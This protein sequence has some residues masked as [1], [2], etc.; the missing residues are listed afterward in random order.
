MS[1][2]LWR[3][4]LEHFA[5]VGDVSGVTILLGD[6]SLLATAEGDVLRA[7]RL[8]AASL[9]LADV[10]GAQLGLARR[11]HRGRPSGH[12]LAR[13]RRRSQA[14]DR[15]GPGDDRRAGGRVR[16]VSPRLPRPLTPATSRREPPDRHAARG[17]SSGPAIVFLD[18]TV[19]NVALQRIGQDLPS[20]FFGVLEGQSY[21][22][23]AYLLSLS[24]L[25][26]LAGAL[27][28]AYGRRRLFVIGLVGFGAA[29]ILCGLAPN[30]ET[31]IALPDRPGRGRGAAR[32]GLAGAAD[33]HVRGR[34]A[35]PRL[36]P[37]G[38]RVR[39]D[40]D[41]RAGR[42]RPPRRDGLVAGRLLPQRAA[43]RASPCGRPGGT[44]QESRD[45][46]AGRSVRLARAPPWWPWPWAASRSARSTAS[47]T[48][49][50]T[51]SGRSRWSSA[52]SR[53]CCSWSS[54]RAADIRSCR[55]ACSG[56]ATSR[57]RT[58][59]RC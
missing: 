33:E 3:E 12:R 31:L 5:A 48:T 4:A 27:A 10:G 59:P 1:A 49:G 21:V 44:S 53:A 55:S 18:S 25:L 8:D 14:A 19:V 23:N 41:P 39:R 28:D 9:R 47:S 13:S 56:R 54:W 15:R 42:R 30:M 37:V 16:P 43:D 50:A 32:A 11:P 26:I 51:P 20:G 29:S 24:A 2:P 38:G 34:R 7:V 40:V 36:R 6:F 17:R 57:S 58:S 52:P 45:P 35:R 22:Y 46:D